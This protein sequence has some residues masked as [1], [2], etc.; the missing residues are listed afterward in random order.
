[1]IKIS[2]RISYLPATDEPLSAD[3]GILRGDR[4]IWLYDVGS[5][6]EDAKVICAFGGEATAILSHFHA[7]HVGNLARLSPLPVYGGAFTCKKLGGGTPVTAD[8]YLEDGACLHL[9]PLPSTH[10]K[11]CVGLEVDETYAFVGDALYPA[12][13]NGR[14]VYNVSLLHETIEVLTKLRAPYL[15]VSHAVPFVQAREEALANLRAIYARR[16]K[17][18]AYIER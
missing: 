11:G 9:F 3:V 13:K 18:G 5:T 6:A 8:L 16:T 10:A 7:D 17:N 12:E 2:D 14:A 4:N 1:M 15:L